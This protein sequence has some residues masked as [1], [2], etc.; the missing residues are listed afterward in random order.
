[1]PTIDENIQFLHLVLTNDGKPAP[2][3][4]VEI[5]AKCETTKP[6]AEAEHTVTEDIAAENSEEF[7]FP[8][9]QE[10]LTNDEDI[11]AYYS[12]HKRTLN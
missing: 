8:D 1:M 9:A 10:Y 5:A 3:N 12:Y 6:K 4:W 7:E 2:I 11:E